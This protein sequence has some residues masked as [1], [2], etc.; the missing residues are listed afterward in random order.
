VYPQTGGSGLENFSATVN[1]GD[2][3]LLTLTF[4]GS[5]VQMK[6]LDWNT[7]A[8]AQ[9]NY[10]SAGSL[11]F[12]G[13]RSSPSNFQGFFTGLMTEWYHVAPYSGNEGGVSYTNNAVALTSAWMWIDEFDTGSAGAGPVIFRNQTRT[14]FANDHQ[15]YPFIAH[16]AMAYISAHQ[17]MTGLPATASPSKVTLTT[18][19]K[20]TSTPS[21]RAAYTLSGQPQTVF[22][23]AGATVLGV[24]PGTSIR[25][26]IN[27]GSRP[28]DRWVFNGTSGTEATIAAGANA[29]YVLYHLVREIVSY[30][31]AAGGLALPGSSAPV[32]RY[33]VPPPVASAT[34]APVAA[35]T[36]I[37]TEPVVIFALLG[38]NASVNGTI[39]GAAGERWIA[40]AQ[41]WTITAEGLIPYPIVFFQQYEVSIGYSVVGGGT[42]SQAPEFTAAALGRLTSTPLSSVATMSWFDAGSAYSFTGIVVGSAGTERWVLSGG[43]VPSPPAI[44]SPG[45]KLSAVY[46]PQYYVRLTVNDARGGTVSGRSGWFY[47]GTSLTA[48]ASTIQGWHFEG[49]TGSGAGA[50]S[51]NSQSIDVVVAGPLNEKATFYV[52]LAITADAGT[53]IAFSYPSQTG[54]VQAGTTKTLYIPSSNVTL[55]ATPSFFIFSFASWQGASGATARSP[56]VLVVDSPSAVTGTSSYNYAGVLVLASAAAALLINILGGLLWIRGRRNRKRFGGFTPG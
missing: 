24:D 23:P 46:T 29:T 28:F 14:T 50:Y 3:V 47:P 12:V 33:E 7:G 6:A 1:S 13:S 49:W 41:N 10:S 8:A 27:S 52:K 37:G 18:Y 2:S 43:A 38:S 16:G 31:V 53:N 45:E 30:Q 5:T 40:R 48:S 15:V 34:A 9:T 11:S 32:L 42:P 19:T 44:S 25:I 4:A 20:E 26:S 17:F 54:T 35:T 51:G 55:R 21:L 36:A 22:I 56:L 39:T